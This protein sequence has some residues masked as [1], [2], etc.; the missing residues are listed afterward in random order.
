PDPKQK[1]GEFNT[2]LKA[3]DAF[4]AGDY[5]TGE[6]LLRA[7]QEKDPQMYVIPFMLGEAA[8]RQGNW[9]QAVV[10]LKKCLDL[11]PN[12]DQAMTALAKALASMY[13]VDEAKPWIQK[14]LQYNPQNFR[15]WYDLG[16]IEAKSDPN[17]AVT[18]YEKA[19]AIQPNFALVR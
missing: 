16:R 17:A 9:E 4:R 2:I 7:I 19:I 15:A 11:N 18:A 8:S 12:L 14:A 13:K 3:N 10:E 1:L 5:P 6:K